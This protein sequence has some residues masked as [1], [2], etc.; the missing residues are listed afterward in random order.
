MLAIITMHSFKFVNFNPKISL[1][2]KMLF[3]IFFILTIIGYIL[4]FYNM[5]VFSK[6]IEVKVEKN[7]IIKEQTY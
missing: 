5:D 2:I 3:W 7:R 6:K 4:I 1:F